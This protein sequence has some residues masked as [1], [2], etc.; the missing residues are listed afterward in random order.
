MSLGIIVWGTL[1]VAPALGAG[2]AVSLRKPP[3]SPLVICAA[4]LPLLIILA[5]LFGVEFTVPVANVIAFC[6]AYAGYCLA[7][8][9]VLNLQRSFLKWPVFVLGQ[10]PIGLGYLMGTVG[11]LA[12][13][14]IVG[15]AAR[16][17]VEIKPLAG[18]MVCRV[19]AWDGIGDEGKQV[20]LLESWRP[21]PLQRHVRRIESVE[22]LENR[23]IGCD[24]E[25]DR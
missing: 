4:V 13:L 23:S 9:S 22:G 24:L 20:D 16:Q 25:G 11:T 15:D 10:I 19:T 7:A 18:R 8:F 6:L 1:L 14:L 2:I 17:P 21:L 5:R 12:L 3:N